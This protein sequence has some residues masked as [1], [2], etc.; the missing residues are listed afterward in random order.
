MR[1]KQGVS[2][3]VG[4]RTEG[5]NNSIKVCMVKDKRLKNFS[6]GLST[7]IIFNSVLAG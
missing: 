1:L 2:M 4:V 5:D 3:A 6:T 7:V